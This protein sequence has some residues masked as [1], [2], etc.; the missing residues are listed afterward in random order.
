VDDEELDAERW[1]PGEHLLQ[2][3][4]GVA[5]GALGALNVLLRDRRAE[6][7]RLARTGP[8]LRRDGVAVLVAVAPELSGARHPD[9][10]GR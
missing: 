1:Q 4:P 6:V 2:H 9:I 3:W 10:N 8:G 7:G 5:A